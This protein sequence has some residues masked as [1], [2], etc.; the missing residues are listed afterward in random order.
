ML[1][2]GF[3]L[4]PAVGA[5]IGVV[6]NHIAIK[7]LF[8]PY[9]AIRIGGFRLP[10]TP[11]LIPR[12][13]GEIAR[14]IAHTF[15]ANLLSGQDIHAIITGP[16]AQKAIE[17]KVDEFF[18]DLGPMGAMLVSMKPKV[19]AKI[20][21]AVEAVATDALSAN[22]DLDVAAKI[23]AR[24]NAMDIAQLENLV[25]GFSRKQFRYITLFGGILGALIGLAQALLNSALGA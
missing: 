8:R 5:L 20:Q 6:T 4:F 14:G 22:G 2:I 18:A 1:W 25:L 23:E 13:R 7:M 16:N 24:I 17:G 3:L 11:G 15:E 9:R 12:Q 10:F 21:E 19:L